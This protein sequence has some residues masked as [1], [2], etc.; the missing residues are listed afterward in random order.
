[1]LNFDSAVW[2]REKKNAV[3]AGTY[4][5]FTQNPAMKNHLLSTGNK[6]LAED[7]PLGPVWGSGLWADDPRANGPRQWRGKI[8]SVRRFLPFAKQFAKRD[9]VGTPGLH[10]PVP[11]S[12]RECWNSRI[13]RQRSIRDR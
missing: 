9:R 6:R 1:M 7:S 13:F 3:L 4:A 8:C 12:Y 2:D 10:T 11:H 5:K